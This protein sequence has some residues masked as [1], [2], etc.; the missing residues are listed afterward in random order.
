[1]KKYPTNLQKGF[2]T[3]ASTRKRVSAA[4]TKHSQTNIPILELVDRL[5]R[6]TT[7]P[8]NFFFFHRYCCCC[9]LAAKSLRLSSFILARANGR[10]SSRKCLEPR[11][12]G[13]EQAGRILQGNKAGHALMTS[14]AILVSKAPDATV[15]H[16]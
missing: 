8:S 3:R 10:D 6:L 7:Q 16:Q 2:V 15:S 4:A 5:K 13:C 11:P 14:S 9:A 12:S 1:M